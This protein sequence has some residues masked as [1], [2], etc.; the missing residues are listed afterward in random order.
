MAGEIDLLSAI[1]SAFA[2][3]AA[4]NHRLETGEGQ[5][6]D[7][8]ST[9]AISVLVGDV[10]MDYLVNGTVQTRRGNLDNYMAPHNCYRCKGKD[11]WISVRLTTL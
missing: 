5:H 4:L 6:I 2:I 1:T 7:L 9:E 8:S 10:L 11:K 3:L